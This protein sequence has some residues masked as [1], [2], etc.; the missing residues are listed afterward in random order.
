MAQVND[1][2]LI[3]L[4]NKPLSFARIEHIEP[5]VK[6]GWFQV[7]LFILQIPLQGV[8]WILR[9]AYINGAEFTLSGKKMRIDKVDCPQEESLPA[10]E[11]RK[12]DAKSGSK[13]GGA[14]V[15]DLKSLLKNR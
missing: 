14:K 15:I 1:L 4:E 3:Y 7:K 13:T 9:D 12:T 11:P 10:G 5:D 6:P 2:V 8:T